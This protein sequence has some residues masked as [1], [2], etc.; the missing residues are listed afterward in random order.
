M[1]TQCT[2]DSQTT[3]IQ[4]GLQITNTT[5]RNNDDNDENKN[6]DKN[7]KN[8]NHFYRMMNDRKQKTHTPQ[9]QMKGARNTKHTPHTPKT[10][11]QKPSTNKA[12]PKNQPQNDFK[13]KIKFWQQRGFLQEKIGQQ[14]DNVDLQNL[15][16]TK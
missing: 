10:M 13:S 6:D 4:H 14:G 15:S 9:S 12:T 7:D 8:D 5:T 2:E 11:K 3:R 16:T 1:N